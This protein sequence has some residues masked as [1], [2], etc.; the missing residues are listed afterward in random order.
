MICQKTISL[1][2][3]SFWANLV[4]IQLD[5]ALLAT[6]SGGAWSCDDT[7][8]VCG[9]N[10]VFCEGTMSYTGPQ[11]DCNFNLATF[12]G[13]LGVFS[14]VITWDVGGGG[15]TDLVSEAS[16]GDGDIPFTVP[17]S[18][19]QIIRVRLTFCGFGPVPTGTANV[20]L[21]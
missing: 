8:S 12:P 17:V 21:T 10:P 5:G 15:E 16:V 19:G 9:T 20:L 13:F 2:V 1:T 6:M 3:L 7:G 14:V 18:T 4:W 11:T